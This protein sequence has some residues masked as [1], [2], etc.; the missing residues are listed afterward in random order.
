MANGY[1]GQ[2][3]RLDLTKQTSSI[4]ETKQYEEWRGANG[5][6]TAIFWDLCRNPAIPGSDPRNVLVLMTSPLAGTLAP[7]TGRTE[8]V[9]IG[10]QAYPI[11]WFTRSNLGGRFAV[12]LKNAGWDGIVIEGKA[13]AL[14]WVKIVNDKV[15]FEDAKPLKGLD[16]W[17][18]QMD[19]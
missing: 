18:T 19:I 10:L 7:S 12:M 15:S 14:C 4:I 8:I 2:I 17:E 6:G 11:D 1:T 16:C 3:L 13:N 9:G 5:I